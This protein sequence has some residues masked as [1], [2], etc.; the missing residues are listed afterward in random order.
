MSLIAKIIWQV[1]MQLQRPTSL[2]DL[3]DRCAVSPFHM[4]RVFRMATGHAPMTYLRAR[5]LS[6]AAGLLAQGDR[7]VLQIA[8]DLQ[9][10]SHAA[11]TR[12]FVSYFGVNPRDVRKAR[13]TENLQM[14]EPLKMDNTAFV[15][16]SPPK[17]TNMDA[18]RVIGVSAQ[19]TFEN[20]SAIPGLWQQFNA[21]EDEVAAAP[22]PAFGVCCDADGAGRFRYVAGMQADRDQSVPKGMDEIQIPAG[23]YAVFQHVGHV[24]DMPKT[25]HAIWNKAL[26]ESGLSLRPA[27]DFERYDQRFDVE[28]GRG[29]VEIWIPVMGSEAPG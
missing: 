6:H 18:M 5:R 15:D 3:A 12:A 10:G 26:P 4:A 29:T 16:V 17:L 20:A 23:Q 24:A 27:P 28:T 1:E 21:R 2:D 25:V 11:F 19:C 9:Y 22:G 13:S 14:M 7:E 8:F